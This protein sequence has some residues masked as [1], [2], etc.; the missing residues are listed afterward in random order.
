LTSCAQLG[1]E[2]AKTKPATPRIA[3][4]PFIYLSPFGCW[5]SEARPHLKPK[6]RGPPTA[7]QK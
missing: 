3:F 4:T 2:N 5:T 7:M 6:E 1:S